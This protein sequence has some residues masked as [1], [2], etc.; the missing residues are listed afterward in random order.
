MINKENGVGTQYGRTSACKRLTVSVVD[1]S[2]S[3]LGRLIFREIAVL[4]AEIALLALTPRAL[5]IEVDV[6]A[7][8]VLFRDCLRFWMPLEPGEVLHVEATRLPLELL[9]GKIPVTPRGKREDQDK[10]NK[11]LVTYCW[12]VPGW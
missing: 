2:R 4:E 10:D 7:L 1:K 8:L 12:Y 3:C 5:P 6:H 11:G 9:R